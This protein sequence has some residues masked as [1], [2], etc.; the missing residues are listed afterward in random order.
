MDFELS[1]AMRAISRDGLLGKLTGA[2]DSAIAAKNAQSEAAG[3]SHLPQY[4]RKFAILQEVSKAALQKTCGSLTLAHTM[5]Q[6]QMSPYSVTS[7]FEVGLAQGVYDEADVV[8]F[9]DEE[10]CAES[11]GA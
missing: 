2:I 8:P 4:T 1:D 10:V 11:S 9:G 7:F 5:P 6:A 3:R